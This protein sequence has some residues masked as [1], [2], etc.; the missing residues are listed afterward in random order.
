MKDKQQHKLQKFA[1]GE[2]EGEDAKMTLFGIVLSLPA[3]QKQAFYS[4]WNMKETHFVQSVA[5]EA[6]WLLMPENKLLIQSNGK[7]LIT[8]SIT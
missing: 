1:L 3:I 4:L 5:T 2:G 6:S 8:T 7:V